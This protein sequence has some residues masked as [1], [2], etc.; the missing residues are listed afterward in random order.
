MSSRLIVAL[1]LASA[2]F[3]GT[4][5]PAAAQGAGTS[6]IFRMGLFDGVGLGLGFS[7]W[8]PG[9]YVS[10]FATSGVALGV[11][12]G[13]YH[14]WGYGRDPFWGYRPWRHRWHGAAI[15][16]GWASPA[17]GWDS[18]GTWDDPWYW[19]DVW[20]P[21]FHFSFG[22]SLGFGWSRPLWISRPLY[23]WDPWF[24]PST[25]FV[26]ARPL[27]IHDPWWG[28]FTDRWVVYPA[29][30]VVGTGT[31]VRRVGAS[32]APG[33]VTPLGYK[34]S[35]GRRSRGAKPRTAAAPPARSTPAP[36]ARR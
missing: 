19:D 3:L 33:R 14:P 4:G 13:A 5:R 17:W 12:M 36:T 8:T 6:V 7:A 23:G 9:S 22:F 35:P 18:Y 21:G 2:L 11:S 15:C 27:L 29:P 10:T 20:L 1:A 16:C 25:I 32:A 30:R 24:G 28:Y 26:D 31:F 34:E